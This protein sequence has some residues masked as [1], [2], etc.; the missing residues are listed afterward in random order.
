VDILRT[1]PMGII[2]GILQQNPFF[3]PPDQLLRELRE[4]TNPLTLAG[5][6][7]L[8][9]H[10]TDQVERRLV[11]RQAALDEL[12]ELRRYLRD[13]IALSGLQAA[14]VDQS[15]QAI[16]DSIAD[17]LLGMLRVDF[18]YVRLSSSPTSEPAVETAFTATGPTGPIRARAMGQALTP[19]LRPEDDAAVSSIPNPTGEGLV[20]LTV[21]SIGHTGDG[22]G[23]VAAGTRR[24]DFLSKYDRLLLQ[25]GANQVAIALQGA[26]LRVAQNELAEATRAKAVLEERQ[27]L[28]RELHDTVTQALYSVAL[29]AEAADRQLDVGDVG[30]ARE[31]LRDVRTTSREALSEMRLLL[32]E[33]RQPVFELKDLSAALRARLGAVEARS[34]L[35]TEM[36]LE[37][38]L[39]LPGAVAQD[40]YRIAQEALNNVLKHGH[41]SRVMVTLESTAER[42]HL[43]VTDDGAGFHPDAAQSGGGLG[44]NG[45]RERA[46]QWGGTLTIESAPGGG[47]RVQ[48]EVPK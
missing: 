46:E 37:E 8:R 44:L 40:L 25:V 33:L 11:A 36:R 26:Q 27:R 35:A 48:V 20:C 23:V 22:M 10:G 18:V 39:D 2:G 15:P 30:T 24:S 45:M 16:V 38:C 31:H 28:A 34:G 41:A 47:T 5:G 19:W 7:S 4:R 43:E 42:V 17:A 32:F 21:T 3:V 29:W 13:L 12:A 9:A 6:S 1:H 14:W